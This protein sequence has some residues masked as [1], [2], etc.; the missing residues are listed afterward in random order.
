MK[1]RF[2]MIVSLTPA[3]SQRARGTRKRFALF[4][5]KQQLLSQ[6]YAYPFGE[7][8]TGW[9]VPISKVTMKKPIQFTSI[10]IALL[11]AGCQTLGTGSVTRDRMGYAAAIGE[12][13]KEQMLLNIVKLRYLDTPVYLSVFKPTTGSGSGR[14]PD[15]HGLIHT[16]WFSAR[17]VAIPT[18]SPSSRAPCRG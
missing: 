9:C 10:L 18:K 6:F 13:W 14:Q 15:K 3:L 8:A 17:R 16:V 12:S 4:H 1:Q 7:G 2:A 5:V 11:L